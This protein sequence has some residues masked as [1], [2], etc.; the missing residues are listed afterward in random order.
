MEFGCPVLAKFPLRSS[1]LRGPLIPA[2]EF[3]LVE[4]SYHHCDH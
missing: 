1:A 2:P 3:P 4:N